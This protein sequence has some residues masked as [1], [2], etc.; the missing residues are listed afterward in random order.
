MSDNQSNERQVA[1]IAPAPP[2]ETRSVMRTMAER[3]GMETV[4]FERTLLD[5]V[6]PRNTSKEAVAA[7][8]VVASEYRLNPFTREIFA[9]EGQGGG[10]R[11]I[12]SIDGWIRLVN[13]HPQMNGSTLTEIFNTNGELEAVEAV[14]YRKDRSQPTIIR[15]YLSE[16]AGTTMP[17]KKWPRRMLRHKAFIQGARIAFGFAGIEDE[18]EYERFV[19]A[20]VKS[21]TPATAHLPPAGART[22][23]D[24]VPAERAGCAAAPA[25]EAR[26][27]AEAVDD[28]PESRWHRDVEIFAGSF[29]EG[30]IRGRVSDKGPLKGLTFAV[31]AA[32]TDPAVLAAIESMLVEG[33]A[34]QGEKGRA[35]IEHQH[36]AEALRLAKAISPEGSTS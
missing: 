26:A 28:V 19:D 18:D 13:E 36:L 12:V 27:K 4:A 10:V 5:T 15:E 3:Y 6:M 31:A 8:L 16:C 20:T 23:R 14:F 30:W 25:V 35:P 11:P 34:I 33:A 21:S 17:W 2:R 32:S 29:P 7:F 9:F 24:L 22:L 1:A